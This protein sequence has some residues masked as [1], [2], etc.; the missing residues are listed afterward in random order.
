MFLVNGV[1]PGSFITSLIPLPVYWSNFRV[2]LKLC[3][4]P[5]I[6]VFLNGLI[7]SAVPFLA[8]Q[9]PAGQCRRAMFATRM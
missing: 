8:D 5:R 6:C 2:Y 7:L 1:Y 4:Q 9:L 3:S